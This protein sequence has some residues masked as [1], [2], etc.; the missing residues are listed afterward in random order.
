LGDPEDGNSS[1]VPVDADFLCDKA[2]VVRDLIKGTAYID[3]NT[4]K[5]SHDS[6]CTQHSSC[7]EGEV[8]FVSELSTVQC[9]VVRSTAARSDGV[10]EMLLRTADISKGRVSFI[11]NGQLIFKGDGTKIFRNVCNHSQNKTKK[12]HIPE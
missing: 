7:N 2:A 11:C 9:S 8:F 3:K 10:T 12:H 5:G 4:G 6:S 1:D